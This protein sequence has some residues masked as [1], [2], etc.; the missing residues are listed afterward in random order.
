MRRRCEGLFWRLN[1]YE[2]FWPEARLERLQPYLSG[3]RPVE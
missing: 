3:L 1:R 2:L